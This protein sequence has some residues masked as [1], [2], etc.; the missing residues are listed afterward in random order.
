M[1]ELH[2]PEDEP[3]CDAEFDFDYEKK[4]SAHA[5]CSKH[6]MLSSPPNLL[7]RLRPIV[8]VHT[9]PVVGIVRVCT[10][11][12][13]V[14]ILR[15]CGVGCWHDA[16]VWCSMRLPIGRGGPGVPGQQRHAQGCRNASSACKGDLHGAAILRGEEKPPRG[17]GRVSALP[18]G[19]VPA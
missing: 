6:K 17:H 11:R 12:K 18:A 2:D 15:A 16:H 8:I 5:K 19:L 1:A 3:E 4:V 13:N 9:S 10:V 7:R 14:R